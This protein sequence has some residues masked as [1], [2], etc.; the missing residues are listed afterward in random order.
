MHVLTPEE[1][2]IKVAL[3][4]SNDADFYLALEK[5]FLGF[6]TS[7]QLKKLLK[8]GDISKTQYS[9]CPSGAQTFYKESLEY[10]PKKM[11]CLILYGLMLFR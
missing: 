8:D 9:T 11:K 7:T 2:K 5:V 10:V 4:I 6:M 3:E 1:I